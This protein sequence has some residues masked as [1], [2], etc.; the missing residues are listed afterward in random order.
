M[1]ERKPFFRKEEKKPEQKTEEYPRGWVLMRTSANMLLGIVNSDISGEIALGLR[2]RERGQNPGDRLE[3][4]QD[5]LSDGLVSPMDEFHIQID[6][7]DLDYF[8]KRLK[9]ERDK[10]NIGPGAVQRAKEAIADIEQMM[11]Y[12]LEDSLNPPPPQSR[13]SRIGNRIKRTLWP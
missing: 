10:P 5:S 9:E 7:G 6:E 4:L 13:V 11:E 3:R 12:D 2:S 8:L 1:K